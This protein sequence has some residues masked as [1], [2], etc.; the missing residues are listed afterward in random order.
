MTSLAYATRFQAQAI[1]DG[2]EITACRPCVIVDPS[3]PEED[4]SVGVVAASP[5]TCV[6]H[7]GN[8]ASSGVQF[9]SPEMVFDLEF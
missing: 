7:P 8:P 4:N 1:G 3:H 2:S 9:W 6:V 5:A